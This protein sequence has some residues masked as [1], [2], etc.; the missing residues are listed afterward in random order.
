MK[1]QIRILRNY[2]AMFDVLK[3]A[4]YIQIALHTWTLYTSLLAYD[5]W[6]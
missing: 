2:E 4:N 3:M 1:V 6:F 5:C